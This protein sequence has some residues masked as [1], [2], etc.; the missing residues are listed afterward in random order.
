MSFWRG[1]SS[2]GAIPNFGVTNEETSSGD[3]AVRSVSDLLLVLNEF[4]HGSASVNPIW[5]FNSLQILIGTTQMV[6]MPGQNVFQLVEGTSARI[7]IPGKATLGLGDI[8][9][10]CAIPSP[11]KLVT[12]VWIDTDEDGVQDACEDPVEGMIVKLYTKPQSGNAEL[13]ATTMTDA[14]GEY[15]FTNSS[16]PDETWET[17]FDNII[18]GDSYF[19]VFMGDGYDEMTDEVTVGMARYMH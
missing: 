12:M 15:Y 19:I 5:W 6:L 17:G 8:E 13:V 2:L 16:D 9:L 4:G 11:S 14:D 10:C 7:W 3:A 1:R 18:R